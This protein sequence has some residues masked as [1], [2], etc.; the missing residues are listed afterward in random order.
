MNLYIETDG[1]GN[2]INHPAF[3]DNLLHAFTS[4]PEHF[5]LFVRVPKPIPNIFQVIDPPTSSYAKIDGVWT[6][7]WNIRDMTEDEKNALIQEAIA[8]KESA[9]HYASWTLDLETL[10]WVP[11]VPMPIDDKKYIWKE[12]DVSWVEMP[13]KPDDGK[14]YRFDM[15][16][17]SWIVITQD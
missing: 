16:T 9:I 13:V 7:V 4:I 10:L 14:E 12:V 8:H 11:P 1:N 5:E 6:D 15:D 3:E 2:C 17:I